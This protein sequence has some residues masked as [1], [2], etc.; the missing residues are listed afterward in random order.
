MSSGGGASFL[1][2]FRILGTVFVIFKLINVIFIYLFLKLKIVFVFVFV[3][4]CKRKE[5]KRKEQK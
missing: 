3:F 4:V 2:F 5:K 1:E